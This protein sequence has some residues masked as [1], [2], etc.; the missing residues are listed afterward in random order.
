LK[1]NLDLNEELGLQ[2]FSFPM[3]YVDLKCKN[4]LATT[5]G[6][7]GK[8]WN[9]KYLRA[10]QCVLVRTRGLVGTKRDYFLKAFGHDHK[11]FHKILLMPDSYIIYR[12][13][14]EGDGSTDLWWSQVCALSDWEY[15]IFEHIVCTQL[16]RSV[17]H[18][19]LPRGVREALTHYMVRDDRGKPKIDENSVQLAV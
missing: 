3:R 1:I 12:F 8:H 9:A 14:H 18:A 4:R 6:N 15:E 10:I 19:E 16:F 17:N 7:I 11:E 2:I 5:P 13:K